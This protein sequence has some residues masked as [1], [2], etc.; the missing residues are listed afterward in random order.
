MD[1]ELRPFAEIDLEDSF[2]DSLKAAYPE[3]PQWF[4]KKASQ[5]EK[6]YV[7]CFEDGRVADS[8]Y[9]TNTNR[10]NDT[11]VRILCKKHLIMRKYQRKT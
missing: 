3:F 7:S 6:A 4:A 1:L 8:L 11:N 10:T 5:G 2:F 9:R